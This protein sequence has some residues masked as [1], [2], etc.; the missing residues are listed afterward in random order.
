MHTKILTIALLVLSGCAPTTPTGPA[1]PLLPAHVEAG[2]SAIVAS[3]LPRPTKLEQNSSD[4]VA[5]E[6]QLP[7]VPTTAIEGT[8]Q[9]A[10]LAMR[11]AI[12]VMPEAAPDWSYKV[13][14]F[15]PS[16]GPGLVHLIG[17]ARF[18]GQGGLSWSEGGS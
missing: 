8:A 14:V 11:N 17:T 9:A 2:A 3:G 5:A 15:G 16:P 10:V 6:I 12:Y 18:S 13:V 7:A 4:I 1:V